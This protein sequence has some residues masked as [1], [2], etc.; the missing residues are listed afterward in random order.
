MPNE[1]ILTPK[2]TYIGRA[3][4]PKRPRIDSDL[5]YILTEG[6][7]DGSNPSPVTYLKYFSLI[8]RHDGMYTDLIW[9]V[10]G[11]HIWN[12][13]QGESWIETLVSVM[14]P[15]FFSGVLVKL[16]H[17]PVFLIQRA[18]GWAYI[19]LLLSTSAL[20]FIKMLVNIVSLNRSL[21]NSL[22]F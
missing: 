14:C 20:T 16:I 12:I 4:G 18:N 13:S 8:W 5:K 22:V 19:Y 15:A 3:C 1:H 11:T 7:V 21:N 9:E 10:C 2:T 6:S 17:F